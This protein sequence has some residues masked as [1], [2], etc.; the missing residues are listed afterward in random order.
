MGSGTTAKM[1]MLNK[2]NY[3]GFE[4]NQ[5]YWEVS[6]KRVAKYEGKTKE[7]S[8]T[9]DINDSFGN[10]DTL[11]IDSDTDKEVEEKT[12]MFNALVDQ[13]NEYFNEMSVSIL[14]TLKLSFA[15]KAN[16]KRVENAIKASGLTIGEETVEKPAQ[17]CDIVPVKSSII[18]SAV[19]A[20]K[21]TLQQPKKEYVAPCLTTSEDAEGK[22]ECLKLREESIEEQKRNNIVGVNLNGVEIFHT[23]AFKNAFEY[24]FRRMIESGEFDEILR[25]V[26][27]SKAVNDIIEDT[28]QVQILPKEITESVEN[29]SA[30]DTVDVLPMIPYPELMCVTQKK[31]GR[32]RPKGS[33]DTKP[34]KLRE[35][36]T[37]EHNEQL[38][39]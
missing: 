34:R 14:K 12:A 10:T 24:H 31:R 17:G 29:G 36:K 19:S 8:E 11:I 18:E 20:I 30:Y 7:E 35:K 15:S 9:I 37:Q 3:I 21:G 1:A 22:Y 33:K 16:D 6:L 13:M 38:D 4:K 27:A 39:Y 26:N 5:E 2:R 25:E 32:G 28:S 23:R